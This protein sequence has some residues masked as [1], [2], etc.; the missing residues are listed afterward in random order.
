MGVN[1]CSDILVAVFTSVASVVAIFVSA[2]I[3]RKA[4]REK[5]NREFLSEAYANLFA[6]YVRWLETGDDFD[7]GSLIAAIERARLLSSDTT[8]YLL[9][10]F[11]TAIR[12]N[13]D[14]S[15]LGNKLAPLRLAMHSELKQQPHKKRNKKAAKKSNSKNA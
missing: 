9:G 15:I 1:N 10:D 11:E 7:K 3:S 6:R 14:V 4:E 13:A 12:R 2:S 5:H 8:D